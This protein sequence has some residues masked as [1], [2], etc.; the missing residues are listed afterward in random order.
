ML[1]L[2]SCHRQIRRGE[3]SAAGGKHLISIF[4]ICI[5]A[6]FVMSNADAQVPN[7]ISYQGLLTTS[8]G[9]PVQDGSYN[10]QF[11]LFKS[12]SVGSSLWSETHTDVLVQRGTFSVMLGSIN[13]LPDIFNQPLFVEVGTINP[14]VTFSPR[15]ELTSAPYSFNAKVADSANTVAN[16]AI[17]SVK[18]LD[19]TITNSDIAPNAAI[20]PSKIDTANLGAIRVGGYAVSA[21]PQPNKLLPLSATGTIPGNI[22]EGT[23]LP[24]AHASSHNES[25]SDPINVTTGVIADNAITSSKIQDGTIQRTDVQLS[26]KAPY[27]DT[28]DYAKGAPPAGNAGGDLTGTYP[29]PTIVTD[30]V[31]SA[32]IADGTIQRVDVQSSF[33]APYSD[34]ADYAKGAP[35]AGN[36][37]GDL[38]GTYPNPTIVS[39]AIT[40]AKILDGTVTSA[41]ISDGTIQRVDVLSTFK[42]PYSDTADYAKGAPPAGNAGGDLTGTFPNPTI[43][44]NAVTSAK[45]LDGTIAGSDISTTAAM[46]IATLTTTGNV[47]IGIS[48]PNEKLEVSGN[49][50]SIGG[51]LYLFTTARSPREARLAASGNVGETVGRVNFYQTGYGQDGV[52]AALEG[53][54]SSDGTGAGELYLRT[55]PYLMAGPQ[56]RIKIDRLGN[57]FVTSGNLL[58]PDG[59]VGVGTTSPAQRMDVAGTV[60]MTGLKMTTSPTNGYILTSDASGVGTWQPASI[61][62]TAGG[63]L[64]GTYPNPTIASNAVT[65]AK[66]LDATIATGDLADASVTSA[67]IADG[68]IT[69]LDISTTA[70]L[71]IASLTTTGNVGIGTMS[72]GAKLHLYAGGAGN[73]LQIGNA[74]YKYIYATETNDNDMPIF[75]TYAAEGSYSGLGQQNYKI[76]LRG[77][78]GNHISFYT[79]NDMVNERMRITSAGNVGIGTTSPSAKL[80]VVGRVDATEGYTIG[81]LVMIN[82]NRTIQA[83]DGTAEAPAY[84]F[85]GASGTGMFRTG[86]E[87]VL[88]FSVKLSEKM[89]ITEAGNVG[90]GT[91]SPGATLHLYAGG[92]ANVVQIGNSGYK[93]IYATET[94]D[95]DMPVFQTYA[96]EGSY[97]GLGQQNYRIF[98]RGGTGNHISFYTNNDMANERMRITSAGNVGIGTTSPGNILT[99][100]QNSTTDPIADAWTT[101]SSRRWKT[102]IKPLENALGKVQQLQGVSYDW[103]ADGKHDIGLIAEEVGK[104]IPEVVAYEDNGVDAKSVDYARLVAVLIEAVKEQQKKITELETFVKSLAEEKKSNDNSAKGGSLGELR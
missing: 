47:G 49:I 34:T 27:S 64:T 12:L 10:L 98:L 39:N 101:Y 87:N 5:L 6:L 58:I 30:A 96:A 40:S 81:N 89:R 9:T 33:K 13:P 24:G 52:C 55:R 2:M 15:S 83:A 65:S 68:T 73:V 56:D 79:N 72:P 95:S 38:T 99:V 60:Q 26:F 86:S 63:D 77:G 53:R 35:P 88:A 43:V 45:I 14:N 76:F 22:I 42:A 75:Q 100:V 94:N 85:P 90:I 18:I 17:T 41:D 93:Y 62:G 19:G 104:V 74:G 11:N 70:A 50:K 31:T 29:Y 71:N 44:S 91:M 61:G 7:K 80:G 92:A 1:N 57:V 54:V 16:G 48:E 102:N 32:K 46:N 97:S 67:K 23:T 84:S 8:A 21:T 51:D 4:T 37:G 59:N 103:K 20:A 3:K 66:I 25:G 82:Q 69:G 78:A 36:A 28:A